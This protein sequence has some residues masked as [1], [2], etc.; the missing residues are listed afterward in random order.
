MKIKLLKDWE[1]DGATYKA[2]TTMQVDDDTKAELLA[3]GTAVEYDPDME[4]KKLLEQKAEEARLAELVKGVVRDT[5]GEIAAIKTP[6]K[7]VVITDIKERIED[8]PKRGFKTFGEFANAVKA[9]DMPGGRTDNRLLID[10]KAPSGLNM[11]VDSQGGFLVPEEFAN[12][13]LEKT[14]NE[15]LV[16]TKSQSIPM[17]SASVKIPAVVES[18][19]VDGSRQG[20]VRAYW[21]GE[22]DQYT[23]SKPALGQV[24]LS[25]HKLTG[26]CFVTDELSAW[27]QP[28]IEAIL[29]QMFAREFAFKLDDAAVNGT[30]AGQPL[31]ILNAPCLVSVDKEVGQL[32]D[33]IVAENIL[34][35]WSRLYG[36]SKSNAVWLVSQDATPQLYAMGIAVGTAGQVVYMPPGGVS[37]APYATLMGRPVIEI[38]HAQTLGDKGDIYLVDM[39]Q[40]L[41]GTYSG[42]IEGAT[43]IHIRFDYG[44]TAYR[45]TMWADGQPWW[46]SALTPFK[47]SN[48]QSPFITLAARA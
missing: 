4:A 30:G 44:E 31:G 16:M 23:S 45:W 28:T 25:L 20:G 39:T 32:A 21:K 22:G 34:K 6:K 33:T 46:S 1:F 14:Y 18:S 29:P 37:G 35:M 24:E 38:E 17:M 5:V 12:R 47:G 19:R 3:D 41:F 26:Y 2:G 15:S 27:S 7:S 43:S 42:G 10:S 8:D 11:A 9:A 36:R 40:Y 13:L 48:T